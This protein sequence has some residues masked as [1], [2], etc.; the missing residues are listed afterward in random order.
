M[1]I[2]VE[3]TNPLNHRSVALDRGFREVRYAIGVVGSVTGNQRPRGAVPSE[4]GVARRM[5]EEA[6]NASIYELV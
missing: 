5:E 6:L 1:V 2:P 4:F 3:E